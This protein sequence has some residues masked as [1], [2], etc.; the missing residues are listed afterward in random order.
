LKSEVFNNSI[1]TPY[2]FDYPKLTKEQ[3]QQNIAG[4]FEQLLIFDRITISTNRLNFALFFLI[5]RLGINT[6][7]RLFDN[8]YIKLMIWS[9][10][11]V[12]GGGRQREDGSMDESVIYGQ[13]PVVAATLGEK[14]IDP[15][16][17][18]HKALSYFNIHRDRKR[19]FTSR[20]S[21]NYLV[22][23]GM[24][25]SKDSAKLVIDAYQ[26][27]TLAT[28]GPPF[29]KEPNQLD[30]KQRQMLLNLGQN[31]LE[32]AILSKYNFK[33]YEN[34]TNYEICK[35]NLIHIG[36]AFNIAENTSRLLKL[37][38]LPDLKTLYLNDNLQFDDI[39]KIRHLSNVKFYRKW[40][41]EVGEDA[42]AQEITKEYLNEIKGNS[43]FFDSTEG[44][45]LK[46]LGLFGINTVL[47]ATIAGPAGVAAGYALGLLETFWLDNILKG[48][49]PS[50]FIDDIKKHM[51][52]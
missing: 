44:K 33:S 45:F 19:I 32:T 27:N 12:T 39:F 41:N 9:P 3:E 46:N 34:Y 11:I 4:L 52:E 35:Q 16:E 6:V 13:P 51:K 1:G 29:D 43:K 10:L 21:K 42:N 49:N 17:N 14:D 36:K 8:G 31:V 24:E 23:D 48:K 40:I 22:P 28:L 18:I 7:E 38:N 37:E 47:G 50:M 15:E 26:N 5:S 20:V 25:F 2:G 30:L